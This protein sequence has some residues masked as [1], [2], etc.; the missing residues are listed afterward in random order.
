[1]P[2][3]PLPPIIVIGMATCIIVSSLS[4]Q[5]M[6]TILAFIFVLCSFPVHFLMKKY[7]GFSTGSSNL[8]NSSTHDALQGAFTIEDDDSAHSSKVEFRGGGGYQYQATQNGLH[9]GEVEMH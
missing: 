6:F 2:L 8:S 7:G 3:Y 5:P 1:V 9:S 4:S